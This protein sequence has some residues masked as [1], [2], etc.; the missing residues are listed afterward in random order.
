ME[1]ISKTMLYPLVNI[2]AAIENGPFIVDLVIFH[3]YISLP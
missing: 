2:Q 3:S 1:Y